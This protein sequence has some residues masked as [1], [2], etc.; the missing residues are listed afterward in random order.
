MSAQVH[1][2]LTELG[3]GAF[4]SRFPICPPHVLEEIPTKSAM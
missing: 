2:M 4:I 3:R 1:P